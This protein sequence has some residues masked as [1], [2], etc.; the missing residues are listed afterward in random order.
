M[1]VLFFLVSFYVLTLALQLLPVA[2]ANSIQIAPPSCQS[3][4][5]STYKT[6]EKLREKTKPDQVANR[7]ASSFSLLCYYSSKALE[8]FNLNKSHILQLELRFR[9]LLS[10]TEK[11]FETLP[12]T[13]LQL[14][15][16]LIK[17]GNQH[18]DRK[19]N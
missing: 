3:I 12:I 17:T 4:F 10:A 9:I 6:V 14:I 19:M 5:D 7:P 2:K 13:E 15:H 8:L 11:H 16:P 18:L 1:R